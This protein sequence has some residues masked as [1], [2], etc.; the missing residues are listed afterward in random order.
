MSTN[1]KIAFIGAGHMAY[2]I[3]GGMINAGVDKSSLMAS[4]RNADKLAV[5]AEQFD[6][7]T[8]NDNRIAADNARVVVLCVKPKHISFI[9]DELKDILLTQKPLIITLAAGTVIET[10]EQLLGEH[11]AIVRAMPNLPA[12]IGAG[13]TGLYA[14][15][16]VSEHEQDIA[17]SIFRSVGIT[18]WALHEQELDI[19]TAL[20]GSGPAYIFYLMEAMEDAAIELGLSR[21]TA[22]LLTMQTAFGASKLALEESVEPHVLVERVASPKGT[23]EAALQYLKAQDVKEHIKNAVKQAESR[24]KEICKEITDKLKD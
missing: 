9:I 12:L 10:I 20:S 17:E 2:S 22:R 16:L 13:A 8:T 3:I 19:I 11:L 14:N 15:G 6:I 23:T 18:T 4:N 24:A 5:I 1:G 21:D 7:M